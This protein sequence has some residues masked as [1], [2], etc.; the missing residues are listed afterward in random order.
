MRIGIISPYSL[1]SAGGVQVQV[2]GLARALADR[3]HAVRVLAPCDGAPP[4]TGVTPLGASIH[5]FE[6]HTFQWL[7][8]FL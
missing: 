8:A 2:L 5:H 4:Q 6:S 3:G 1:T 7:C